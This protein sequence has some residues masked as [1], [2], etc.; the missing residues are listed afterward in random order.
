MFN[1]CVFVHV[2]V[3]VLCFFSS[4]SV[5]VCVF[6]R[7]FVSILYELLLWYLSCIVI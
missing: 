4:W 5:R 6:V 3:S 7:L 1:L 2:G